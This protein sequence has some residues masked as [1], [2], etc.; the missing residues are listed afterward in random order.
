[1]TLGTMR[2]ERELKVEV[3]KDLKVREL[4]EGTCTLLHETNVVRLDGENH[5]LH[6]PGELSQPGVQNMI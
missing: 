4:K 5:Q 2:T 1:M 3:R 6:M